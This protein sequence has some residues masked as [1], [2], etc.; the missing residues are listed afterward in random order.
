[1]S[2]LYALVLTN[3]PESLQDTVFVEVGKLISQLVNRLTDQ[4]VNWSTG[5]QVN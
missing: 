2:S 1:V 4:L 5:Q 3:N